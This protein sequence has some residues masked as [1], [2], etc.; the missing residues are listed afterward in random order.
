MSEGREL[1]LSSDFGPIQVEWDSAT[2][3]WGLDIQYNLD[4]LQTW[5]GWTGDSKASLPGLGVLSPYLWTMSTIDLT[6]MA[7]EEETF[8]PVGSTIQDP[9][10]YV[11]DGELT[12][13]MMVLDLITDKIIDPS[14]IIDFTDF[15][16][17]KGSMYGM[18]RNADED[19]T[20]IMGQF[21]FMTSNANL[22]FSSM[23]RT[24]VS[25][26]FSSGEP[27][28]ASKL[29]CYRIIRPYVQSGLT[30]VQIPSS[31]FYLTGVRDREEDLVYLMRLKRSYE[32]DQT[33]S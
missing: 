3:T 14:E 21:R 11:N 30:K 29:Y 4:G 33:Q 20:I 22:S 1:R 27:T 32:L 6:G 15:Y 12:P 19:T 24:E 2:Q 18:I 13:A 28:A 8:F 26:S 10:I 16:S 5:N 9:G 25:T 23:M 31:R 17:S 7:L